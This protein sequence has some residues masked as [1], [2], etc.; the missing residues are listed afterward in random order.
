MVGKTPTAY[1]MARAPASYLLSPGRPLLHFGLPLA[2]C[3]HCTL[4]IRRLQAV[5]RTRASKLLLTK[6]F[7]I[8][9]HSSSGYISRN[10][11]CCPHTGEQTD[12]LRRFPL[13]I[14]ANLMARM[15][16]QREEIVNLSVRKYGFGAASILTKR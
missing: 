13:V 16:K 11:P 2:S 1:S 7:R 12:L 10:V 15:P 5:R 3:P 6:F 4:S 9:S 14:G 8:A